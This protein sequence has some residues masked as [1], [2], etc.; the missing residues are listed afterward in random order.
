MPRWVTTI[1]MSKI[2]AEFKLIYKFSLVGAFNAL[3]DFVIIFTLMYF[4]VEP[5]L[6]NAIC[7]IVCFFLSFFLGKSFVFRTVKTKKSSELI[8]FILV[9]LCAFFFNLIALKV[10]LSAHIN[11]YMSQLLAGIVYAAVSYILSRKWVFKP[12]SSPEESS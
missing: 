2:K 5:Y 4:G 10:F 6:S 3:I 12:A 1:S 11:P 9:F 7:Y 8:R